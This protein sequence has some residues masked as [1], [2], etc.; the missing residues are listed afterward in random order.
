MPLSNSIMMHSPQVC[1]CSVFETCDW[2]ESW[3]NAKDTTLVI[4]TINNFPECLSLWKW[5][6]RGAFTGWTP[7]IMVTFLS[8]GNFV[9]SGF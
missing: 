3:N 7:N 8:K 1:L 4:A 5:F 2:H 6:D 9:K